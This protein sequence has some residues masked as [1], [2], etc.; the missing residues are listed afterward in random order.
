[1]RTMS[2]AANGQSVMMPTPPGE[3][4]LSVP[5]MGGPPASL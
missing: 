5:L 3:Q 4:S 2:P 1:M